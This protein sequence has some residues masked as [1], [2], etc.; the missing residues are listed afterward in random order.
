MV[1]ATTSRPVLWYWHC[2]FKEV[3]GAL[4]NLLLKQISSLVQQRLDNR[5]QSSVTAM[6]YI[7]YRSKQSSSM[8]QCF[9]YGNWANALDV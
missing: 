5:N 8:Q 9:N 6:S 4:A 1:T 2:K 7:Q 3:S